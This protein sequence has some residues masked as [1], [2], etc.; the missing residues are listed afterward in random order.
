MEYL[1]ELTGEW[2]DDYQLEVVL[3]QDAFIVPDTMPS[4]TCRKNSS[5]T[6]LEGGI[7]TEALAVL[8]STGCTP[9]L[10]PDNPVPAA[11]VLIA[12]QV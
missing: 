1:V 6:L 12:P 8:S 4:I 10:S 11:A 2:L 9:V 7:R 5:I 3:G